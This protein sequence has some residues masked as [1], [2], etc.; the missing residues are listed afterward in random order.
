MGFTY[1]VLEIPGNPVSG[2]YIRI[3]KKIQGKW[4]IAV[5][6]ASIDNP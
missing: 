4:L 5:E 1:G 2:H 3:W 6:M